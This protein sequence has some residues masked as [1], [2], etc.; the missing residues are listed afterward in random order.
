MVPT[1]VAGLPP[2]TPLRPTCS[3]RT[4]ARLGAAA[5]AAVRGEHRQ[6]PEH[7]GTAGPTPG[8]PVVRGLRAAGSHRRISITRRDGSHALIAAA[9]DGPRR[10]RRLVIWTQPRRPARLAAPVL[11]QPALPLRRR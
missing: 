2:T 1:G 6:V 3:A 10:R 4:T 5:A 7:L 11:A 8:G 9:A